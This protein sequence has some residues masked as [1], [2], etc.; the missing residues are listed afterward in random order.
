MKKMEK[1]ERDRVFSVHLDLFR[2]IGSKDYSVEISFWN[3]NN[4][5]IMPLSAWQTCLNKLTA[6]LLERNC[7]TTENIILPSPGVEITRDYG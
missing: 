3:K 5:I 1:S 4:E 2:Y 7:F 6:M